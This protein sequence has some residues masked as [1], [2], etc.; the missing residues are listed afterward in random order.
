MADELWIVTIPAEYD[1][2]DL[3]ALAKTYILTTEPSDELLIEIGASGGTVKKAPA[4]PGTNWGVTGVEVNGDEK[5]VTDH[6]GGVYSF[7]LSFDY[8]S[9]ADI[10]LTDDDLATLEINDINY[11]EYLI[12]GGVN[13]AFPLYMVDRPHGYLYRMNNETGAILW[14]LQNDDFGDIEA[15][16]PGSVFASADGAFAYIIKGGGNL[17]PPGEV[18]RTYSIASAGVPTILDTVDVFY[19]SGASIKYP[20]A[21]FDK[22]LERLYVYYNV[23][24]SEFNEQSYYKIFSKAGELLSTVEVGVD[25]D[26]LFFGVDDGNIF[27]VQE[28]AHAP[29]CYWNDVEITGLTDFSVPNDFDFDDLGNLYIY[30]EDSGGN[31]QL[32]KVIDGT[33]SWLR[34]LGAIDNW[35][36]FEGL[37][38]NKAGDSICFY[39][40]AGDSKTQ[41]VTTDN[42]VSWTRD[43][44]LLS[45]SNQGYTYA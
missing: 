11:N 30:F 22:R 3:I 37:S 15:C 42:A 7:D 14:S 20:C 2:L 41:K 40:S 19:A 5:D 45:L 23:E 8:E 44:L 17:D 25:E 34:D 12:F 31:G 28:I 33:L 9:D 16:Y 32:A 4:P 1:G 38:T 43:L 13:A 10:T 27:F 21:W 39:E 36:G 24:P 35:S 18:I 29:K 6:G 26:Y